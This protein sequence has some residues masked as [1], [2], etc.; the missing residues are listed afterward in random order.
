MLVGKRPAIL[1]MAAEAKFVCVG[2]SQVVARRASVRIVAIHTAH[3]P[4]AQRVMVRHTE[5]GLLGLVTL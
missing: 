1:R 3:L 4:F 2:R 5:L